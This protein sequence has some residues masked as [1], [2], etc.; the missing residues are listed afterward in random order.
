MKEI[1]KERAPGWVHY[2][3]READGWRGWALKN[4]NYYFNDI[5]TKRFTEQ[6]RQLIKQTG[7]G[8]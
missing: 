3:W 4:G 7:F 8:K 1:T 2:Y 5:P 6:E